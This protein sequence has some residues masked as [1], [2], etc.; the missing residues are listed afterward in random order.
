MGGFI[1]V[2]DL[3]MAPRGEILNLVEKGIIAKI[4][5]ILKEN[6]LKQVG[7]LYERGNWTSPEPREVAEIITRETPIQNVV[8]KHS[9]NN[10]ESTLIGNLLRIGITTVGDVLENYSV[11][12]FKQLV[13]TGFISNQSYEATISAFRQANIALSKGAIF[14]KKFGREPGGLLD[15]SAKATKRT[16]MKPLELKQKADPER[17]QKLTEFVTVMQK[18]LQKVNKPVSTIINIDK[19]L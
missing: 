9:S 19:E 13:A 17:H 18:T 3:Q 11:E 8:F 15:G 1:K 5:V 2:K 6:S 12:D 14:Y 7:K 4:N 16:R 10:K